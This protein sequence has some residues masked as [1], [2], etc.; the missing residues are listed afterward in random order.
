MN[1]NTNK[2]NLDKKKNNKSL[3]EAFDN[4]VKIYWKNEPYIKDFKKNSELEVKFG[5]L[6]IKDIKPTTKMDYDNVISKLRSL[7]FSSLNDEGEYMLR[8]QNEFLDPSQGNIVLSNIRTEIRGLLGIQEYCKHNDISKLITSYNEIDGIIW[9]RK[10]PYYHNGDKV[11]AVNFHDFNFRLDY[12][13]EENL[14]KTDGRIIKTIENWNKSKKS[15]RYINRVTFTHP[16]IPVRVDISIVKTNV[17][18]SER[19]YNKEKDVWFTNKETKYAYT[20]NEANVFNNPVSYEIEIE[21]NN[22]QIGPGTGYDNPDKL[23]AVLRKSIKYVLMGIQ[24]SNYPIAYREQADVLRKYMKLL[25][26]DDYEIKKIANEDFIG[27]S[28]YTLQVS[29][30]APINENALIPNIRQNYTVTDKADGERSLLFIAPTGKIYLINNRMQVVFTGA[31]TENSEL[32]NSLLDGEIIYQDKYQKYINLFA[33]FDIYFINKENVRALSFI[34]Q[35]VEEMELRHRLS[36]LKELVKN[37]KP[38]SVVPNEPSPI[39]IETKRFY[40]L[41]ANESIFEGCNTILTD[42]DNGLY[43]YETDG[44]I[45][46]P[47]SFGVGSNTI[48]KAGP[49]RKIPWDYSFKWKPP[50]YNTI[51]FLCT[52]IKKDDDKDEVHSLFQD[53]LNTNALI[54]ISQYKTLELRCGYSIKKHGYLNP[55]QDI[56]DDNLPTKENIHYYEKEYKPV[57]FYPTNPVDPNAGFCNILLQKDD[58]GNFQMFSEEGEVFEDNTVVEFRYDMDRDSKWRWVPLRV[59]YDKTALLRQNVLEFG[60]AYHVA[61]SNWQTIHN[62]ISEDML[63]TGNDIPN[64]LADDDVYYNRKGAA[65]Q[66]EAMRDFHNKYVKKLLITSVSKRGGI[67]IDYACGKAGDLAKWTISKLS[68]VFGIDV[69]SDNLDNKGDGA[70]KRYLHEY[71]KF[72]NIPYALFVQGDSGINIRSGDALKTDKGRQISNAVF[73]NGP[74]DSEKLGK[75]VA[76]Q[77]GKGAEGFDVSSCQFAVH[78]FFK[79]PDILFNFM[80]NIAEC[81]KLGG[82]FIGTCYDGKSIFNLLKNYKKGEGPSNYVNKVKT[83]GIVK[84]YDET[85]F[86]DDITSVNYE[87][88]VY[89]ETINKPFPEYLVNFD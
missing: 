43:E 16:D 51:D 19:K 30:I 29:N 31:Q 67:L 86:N 44:L 4:M 56:Y 77:Y 60:N 36:L 8:I 5:T 11:R 83:W 82:Y 79:S 68:F 53:G 73:G 15:F 58:A 18:E 64:E 66:T 48:G 62:P 26:G 85:E 3:Q 88:N 20:T 57:R 34:P 40:P 41:Y 42:V 6:D 14:S 89:Q 80:R 38:L 9:Y 21:V 46:T 87:I 13:I 81:T 71:K 61:N 10:V 75:G 25:H 35:S 69:S 70:C 72:K 22:T 76:R 23:L 39:K 63:K 78:Y 24:C 33:G 52:T 17:V 7:G 54:Q 28:S 65:S 74:K 50:Q 59:R 47:A 45:F 84:D 12:K 1:M 27:P 49:L 2:G 32:Y 55:C 37:L